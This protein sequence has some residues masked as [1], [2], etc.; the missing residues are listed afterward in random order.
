M[1]SRLLR[2][3]SGSLGP[4]LSEG[5]RRPWASTVPEQFFKARR[6]A[7]PSLQ[8]GRIVL[9][10]LVAA[11]L[12]IALSDLA[13]EQLWPGGGLPLSAS[14]VKGLGFVAVTGAL[15]AWVLGRERDRFA[16]RT[17]A[18]IATTAALLEHFRALSARISDIVLLVDEQD[19]IIEA[20]D[21]AVE[22]LGWPRA[23]LCERTVNDLELGTGGTQRGGKRP[24]SYEATYRLA[25]G[26]LLAV[27]VDALTLHVGSRALRQL[28]VRPAAAH[29]QT[30]AGHRDRSWIDV[31]FDMPFIGMAITSPA[32]KRWVRFNNRLCEILGY[33]PD[34][35]AELTWAKMTHPEDLDKDVAEFER[36]L[37][38]ESD[39]YAMEKRFIRKDGSVVHAEI[40]VRCRRMPD[41]S[42]DYFV[43]TVQDITERVQAAERLHRQKNLYAALSRINTAITRLP[44]RQQIFSDVCKTVVAIGRFQFTCV[45]GVGPKPGEYRL[46]GSAGDDHGHI[47]SLVEAG[48]AP[49][50]FE[51]TAVYR[52]ILSRSTVISDP[53]H[54]DPAT[55]PWRDLAVAAGFAGVGAFPIFEHGRIAAILL[56]HSSTSGEFDPEVVTL[57]EEMTRDVS[58]ALENHRREEARADALKALQS[59]EARSRFALEGA[60]HGAWELDVTTGHASFSPVSKR[61]LGYEED[62]ISDSIEE[63]RSRIHPDD[64]DATLAAVKEHLSGRSPAYISEHRVRCKDGSYKWV[65]A[66]GKVLERTDDGAPWKFFGTSTDLTEVR[67]AADKLHRERRRMALAHASAIMGTWD[68][69]IAT[70][71]LHLHTPALFG[72]GDEPRSLTLEEYFALT[73]PEDRQP[74]REV[75]ERHLRDGGEYLTRCRFIWPDGS[76]HWI[77]DRGVLYYDDDGR[78]VSAFGICMDITE[79]VESEQKLKEYVARLERSMLGTVDAISHMVD[80]R[81]PYTGGHEVRVGQLAAALGRELGLDEITCQGLQIIGRVHDIGKITIPAEILSKPGRL[82][83]MEMNIVRTHAQQGYEILKDI[84]FDWP[85]A[86]VI[87]QHHER[88]DGS[89][90][91]RGLKGDEILL[92]ARILAVA[93]VVESMA[94]HRPYRPARGIEPALAEI[95]ANA[96][97]LYDAE[98]AQACIRLFRERGFE[99][100]AS[101]G[102][103]GG[104]G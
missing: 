65:L 46:E 66:R 13:L 103:R 73:H 28:L 63:W 83:D 96:G 87:R 47:R 99:F 82:N 37:R 89:G 10:Y 58:F 31:F 92:E 21:A 40:D 76:V 15:L 84:E 6:D 17:A 3:A 39:G 44:E 57:I 9:I 52:A 5:G 77:E 1:A 32:S 34:E 43:A 41:G 27:E 67:S 79:R 35:V 80:L 45:I 36:V 49:E 97:R 29:E 8:V 22:A 93:D 16:Q 64:L 68:Y 60:G 24:N 53:Y 42:V 38:G 19:R 81:D 72:L 30:V 51:G 50:E 26:R 23:S 91:P 102:L 100:E 61:M 2:P 56:V 101:D 98:V 7:R 33:P 69:D 71:I 86:E 18:Q 20:N 75:V 25:D 90:Y 12:W 70:G 11:T 74:L 14:M 62:E 78:P 55:E 54:S 85:V 95:E 94:S 48:C 4:H 88:M 104:P 59:A